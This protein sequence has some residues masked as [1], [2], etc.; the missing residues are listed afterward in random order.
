MWDHPGNLP[1]KSTGGLLP[2]HAGLMQPCRILFVFCML[3]SAYVCPHDRNCIK[4]IKNDTFLC[5]FN[6]FLYFYHVFLIDGI[7]LYRSW[8]HGLC[9]GFWFILAGSFLVFSMREYSSGCL[10][11]PINAPV[12]GCVGCRGSVHQNILCYV[13]LTAVAVFCPYVLGVNLIAL[14]A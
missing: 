14:F 7:V 3:L 6:V 11:V 5:V 8:A 4:M 1:R 10:C 9:S 12:F 2:E 13:L